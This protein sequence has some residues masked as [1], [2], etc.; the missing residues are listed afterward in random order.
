[1]MVLFWLHEPILPPRP[2][3][4]SLPGYGKMKVSM[5]NPEKKENLPPR[6]IPTIGAGFN[7]VASNPQLLLIPA[8]VDICLLFGPRLRMKTLLLPM[9]NDMSSMLIQYSPPEMTPML[10]ELKSLWGLIIEQFSLFTLLRTF[11]IGV[12]SLIAG[13]QTLTSPLGERPIF[14]VASLNH[15]FGWWLIIALVG[16]LIGCLFYHEVARFTAP[17]KTGIEVKSLLIQFAE[18]VLLS[19]IVLVIMLLLLVPSSMLVSVASLINPFVAQ[20]VL[21]MISIFLLWLVMPLYFAPFAIFTQQ[22]GALRSM[23]TGLR[24][25]RYAF[26]NIGMF[27]LFQFIISQGMD[28]IWNIAPDNSWLILFSVAG[29]AFIGTSL[30]AATFIYY[31]SANLWLDDALKRIITPVIRI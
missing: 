30:L 15:A 25:S 21:F 7:L 13:H 20:I 17:Q 24:L 11:P 28:I 27:L 4:R 19:F 6:L 29:H 3:L 5:E 14:E 8:V 18:S 9:V 16:I 1:M 12:N 10:L 26:A 23:I 22:Q 2:E 31:R